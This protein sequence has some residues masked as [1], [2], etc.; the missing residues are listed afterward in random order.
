MLLRIIALFYFLPF[1]LNADASALRPT[2]LIVFHK[3]YCENYNSAIQH[4]MHSL[5]LNGYSAFHFCTDTVDINELKNR[6]NHNAEKRKVSLTDIKGINIFGPI[7]SSKAIDYLKPY[8]LSSYPTTTLA[9]DNIELV[10]RKNTVIDIKVEK[11]KSPDIKR[12]VS[13]MFASPSEINTDISTTLYAFSDKLARYGGIS[14]GENSKNKL[15]NNLS[16]YKTIEYYSFPRGEGTAII[17][18]TSFPV[19]WTITGLARLREGYGF[20]KR[21]QTSGDY[22]GSSVLISLMFGLEA[23]SIYS[24]LYTQYYL[25]DDN[26][27]KKVLLTKTLAIDG[28]LD[29]YAEQ[30]NHFHY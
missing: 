11:H 9:A 3:N 8:G 10:L 7:T 19:L 25:P 28:F 27:W 16:N 29:T 21:F 23:C 18:M 5:E 4:Y 12:W 1:F 26:R 24:Y 14:A 15:K 17:G 2:Y 22:F 13:H 20:W 6:I 30:H